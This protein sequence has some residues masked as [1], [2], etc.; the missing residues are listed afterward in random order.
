M[1]TQEYV[2]YISVFFVFSVFWTPA[3]MPGK[4]LLIL[5]DPNQM[6]KLTSIL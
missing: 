4:L 6:L 5:Q 3:C 2:F 1:K